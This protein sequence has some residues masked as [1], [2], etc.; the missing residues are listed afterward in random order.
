M[1]TVAITG[2]YASGKTFVLDHFKNLGFM[3]FS[4]DRC[5]NDLYETTEIK[6]KILAILPKLNSFNKQ[7]LAKII[8]NDDNSRKKIEQFIHPLVIE[9][10]FNF[11]NIHQNQDI[12]FAEIPLLF[13]AHF[14]RFFDYILVT[15]CSDEVQLVRAKSRPYFEQKI[16]DKIKEMQLNNDAKIKRSDFIIHTDVKMLELGSQVI[17]ILKKIKH[18]Q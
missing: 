13:E 11:K 17:K 16:F 4:A 10:L 9:A 8:Y 5:V 2:N 18:Q 12:I 6:N 15:I 14:E 7:N 3:T 1:I